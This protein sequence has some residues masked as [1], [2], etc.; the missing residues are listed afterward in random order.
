[1]THL[2]VSISEQ[3]DEARS[4]MK[5]L[6]R[7]GFEK[8][9][10]E[11]IESD[12]DS[13][14]F[15]KRIFIQDGGEKMKAKQA[16]AYMTNLGLPREEAENYADKV[17]KGHSMVLCRCTSKS[18]ANRAQKIINGEPEIEELDQGAGFDNEE[19]AARSDHGR[20]DHGRTSHSA[21]Y[22]KTDRSTDTQRPT[23]GD[24]H[25]QAAEEE[26]HVGKKRSETGGVRVEKETTEEDVQEQVSLR[27]EDVNVER[28]QVDRDLH[29]GE[30]VFE[31]ESFEVSETREEP[32]VEKKTKIREEVAISKDAEE[33]TETFEDTVRKEHINIENLNEQAQSRFEQFEPQLQAHYKENYGDEDHDFSD[34]SRGYRYGMGLAENEQYHGKAWND[35][36]EDAGNQ[37]E[38]QEASS[39]DNFKEAVRFGWYQIRGKEEDYQR[40][41]PQ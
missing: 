2:V 11:F 10:I 26:L 16:M 22:A 31:D 14:N 28:K 1:M 20:T 18:E 19:P 29:A 41:P 6:Q 34:Y 23:D 36:E 5:A 12:P 40:R 39:W 24:K 13:Q 17:K 35:I 8:S 21:K 4:I 15:L 3:P 37:W 25:V 9:D 7:A 30:D 32:V 38:S 27:E 33:H